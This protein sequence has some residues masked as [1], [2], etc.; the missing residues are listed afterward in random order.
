M[1]KKIVIPTQEDVAR[2][3]GQPATPQPGAAQP[4]SQTP[5]ESGPQAGEP[6]SAEAAGPAAPAEPSMEAL[7]AEVEQWKDKCLRAKAELAN[8]QRRVERDRAE[9]LRY[10]NAGLVKAILPILDDLERTLAAVAEHKNDLD[11][12][13]NG[14]KLTLDN[15][16]KVLKDFGV[17]VIEA[18]GKPFDPSQH[19][20]VMQQPS[21][22][23]SEPTVLGEMAKGYLLHERVLRPARVI[24]SKP[25]ESATGPSGEPGEGG[26]SEEDKPKE[27]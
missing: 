16:M 21:S 19:E 18:S 25:A 12:L 3:G 14:V 15:F 20:A 4:A 13:A 9:S 23:H 6:A 22:E 8:Y 7:Q 5:Q 27:K 24:V 26:R 2:Y 10:A 1:K 11:A 17:R